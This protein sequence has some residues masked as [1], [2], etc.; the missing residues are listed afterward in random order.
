MS[1]KV[2]GFHYTLK[3]T[4]G[5]LIDTSDG[6]PP[7]LF[8][9]GSGM[10]IPGLESELLPMSVGEKKV[11]EVASADAYGEVMDDLLITVQKSQFP[12][13]TEIN[14]GDHFQVNE[15][16]MAP[17]FK[18]VKVD[19]E[20]VTLDGNHPLAGHDLVFDVE[21]TEKR[22]ATE[23]EIAHGHAHGEGGEQH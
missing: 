1:K 13:G 6:Q 2:I 19:G 22:D 23:E 3:N 18:V 7:L 16:P 5:E 17:L 12:D 9:E 11:V 14:E 21:I 10:I 8:L 20:N 4:Q 15:E